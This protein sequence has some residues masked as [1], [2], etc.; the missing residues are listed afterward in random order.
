MT[1]TPSM[2]DALA[3]ATVEDTDSK[4]PPSRRGK[5]VFPLYLDPDLHRRFRIE[6]ARRGVSMQASALE[7]LERWLDS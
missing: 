6:A 2:A 3:A 1:K 7:A 4:R 5:A